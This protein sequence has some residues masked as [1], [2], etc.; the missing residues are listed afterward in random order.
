MYLFA[1]KSF[2][3]HLQFAHERFD[4][5]QSQACLR[6][7]SNS[8]SRS[9]SRLLNWMNLNQA[10]QGVAAKTVLVSCSSHVA[11]WTWLWTWPESISA[12][13]SHRTCRQSLHARMCHS[14]HDIDTTQLPFDKICKSTPLWNCK[15]LQEQK[16]KYCAHAHC[17]AR[18]SG[19]PLSLVRCK[20]ISHSATAMQWF[21]STHL[22]ASCL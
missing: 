20:T 21:I 3:K 5:A 15:L 11:G 7:D 4:R 16:F 10:A 17:K 14:D 19:L 22:D 8:V 13:S 12:S 6:S 1:V 9:T 18:L 2:A